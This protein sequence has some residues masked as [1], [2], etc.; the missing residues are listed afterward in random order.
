MLHRMEIVTLAQT[1]AEPL[2]QKS[3]HHP[4][5]FDYIGDV[6]RTMGTRMKLLN[7]DHARVVT[8]LQMQV[9]LE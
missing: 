5:L 1:V 7:F 4:F 2:I 3:I 6:E 8:N 9:R